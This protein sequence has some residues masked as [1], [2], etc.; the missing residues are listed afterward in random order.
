MRLRLF[1]PLVLALLGA[2][3]AAALTPRLVK[4]INQSPHTRGS[5]PTGYAEAGGLAYFS[6]DDAEI[7]RE[8]WR[9]DGTTAGTFLVADTCPGECSG[10]PRSVASGGR[11]YFFRASAGEKNQDH[12]WVTNGSP[13]GTLRLAGPFLFPSQGGARAAWLASQGVLYFVADDGVHGME[14]WRTNGTPAGTFLV[15]DVRPGPEGSNP[16]GLTSFNGRIFFRATGGREGSSLWKS[17]GTAQGTQLVRDPVPASASHNGPVLMKAVGRT[18]FFVAPSGRLGAQLWKS[19]GTTGGT[20]PLTSFRF[21]PGAPTFFD[22]TV[23]GNRLLFVVSEPGKGQELWASDGKP[24]GTRALTS[25]PRADAFLSPDLGHSFLLPRLALGNSLVFQV[26]DG[27]HG[28]ELWTTDGTPKGTRLLRDLCPGACSGAVLPPNVAGRLAFFT[29]TDGVRGFEPWVTDGTV[30][31]TRIVSDLCSGSCNS[32]PYEWNTSGGRAFFVVVDAASNI[33]QLWRSDG[34]AKGTLRVTSFDQ[35]GAL[36]RFEGFEGVF[37]AG[38]AFL[39]TAT[40]LAYG[41]EPWLSDGTPQGTRLVADLNVRNN[42][43]SQPSNLQAAG[44]KVYF[45]AYEEQ[46]GAGALWV[47][48]GTEAGTVFVRDFFPTEE[49]WNPPY[50]PS[51]VDLGGRLVFNLGTADGGFSLWRTD[52]TADGTVRLTPESVR[53]TP[54][55][56]AA[57]G[58]QAFFAATDG[59][60]DEGLWV[61]DGTA[62]GTRMVLEPGLPGLL[63]AVPRDLTVFQGRL[64]FTAVTEQ[65]GRELWRSDGTPGGTVLVKDIDTRP[66]YGSEPRVFTEHGGRLYFNASTSPASGIWSTDGTAAGTLPADLTPGQGP[67]AASF[68]ISAGSRLF[69]WGRTVEA[70]GAPHSDDGLWVTDGTAAGTKRI[71]DRFLQDPREIAKPIVYNGQ[72]YFA[73]TPDGALWKS[74]GTA[75]GTVP[76]L[77]R[78]GRAIRSPLS[79]RILAGQ[80]VFMTYYQGWLYQSDGTQAGTFKLLDLPRPPQYPAFELVPAG[81]RIFFPSEDRDAG[82]ELWALEGD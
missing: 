76:V 33:P 49:P 11:T 43:G 54:I 56:M 5:L 14:L 79:F 47:S 58:S 34:T 48:D 30:A 12:L 74:D 32:T 25:L 1:I 81:P 31:G 73:A 61:T 28:T 39:F 57:L 70:N 82:I 69:V 50:I 18:L 62:A 78:E 52:G 22:T 15:A 77:D 72:L 80:L 45:L 26:D 9:S 46:H 75:A 38:G 10:E 42:D 60:H 65:T 44:G 71:G 64:Y 2:S 63:G 36:P 51:A 7:G 19:D 41:T 3:P 40:D 68:M 55:G 53:V 29:G 35:A 8:L 23:L 16:D 67:L 59:V 13:A 24:G 37:L 17:D 27:P 6:A 21:K 20:A 66:L 4:D